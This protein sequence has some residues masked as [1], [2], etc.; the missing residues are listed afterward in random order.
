MCIRD[1]YQRR[2]HGMKVGDLNSAQAQF[3]KALNYNQGDMNPI[4]I[5][6]PLI[7]ALFYQRKFDNIKQLYI[8]YNKY[9]LSNQVLLS[10]IAQIHIIMLLQFITSNDCQGFLNLFLSSVLVLDN[11]GQDINKITLL[12]DL[13]IYLVLV[14][15]AEKNREEIISIY[16]NP[17]TKSLLE[18]NQVAQDLFNNFINLKFDFFIKQLTQLQSQFEYDPFISQVFGSLFDKILIKTIKI[19]LTPF[20]QISF[21]QIAADLQVDLS[22][23]QAIIIDLIKEKRIQYQYDPIEQIIILKNTEQVA[24]YKRYKKAVK[25]I[26]KYLKDKQFLLLKNELNKLRLQNQKMM[27][28]KFSSEELM[29]KAQMGI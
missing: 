27:M 8:K 28:E 2:V 6:I 15:L 11:V 3:E 16:M 1:R 26:Q 7:N 19:Y 24:R 17:N 9:L 25:V 14:S 13:C 22:Q 20:S 18:F 10:Q 29:M 12:S 4:D 5:V 23:L 21:T